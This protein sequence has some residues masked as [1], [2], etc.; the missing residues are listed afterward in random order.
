MNFPP[1]FDHVLHRGRQRDDGKRY[2]QWIHN[3]PAG[4]G[5]QD[6]R[7]LVSVL[8]RVERRGLKEQ[9]EVRTRRKGGG[10]ST[11]PYS[12]TEAAER[13]NLAEIYLSH[14]V[15]RTDD[16]MTPQIFDLRRSNALGREVYR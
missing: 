6:S 13:R 16:L 7:N 4:M 1:E 2:G 8:H 3:V 10:A 9:S 14:H 11:V 15:Q 12:L 5:G